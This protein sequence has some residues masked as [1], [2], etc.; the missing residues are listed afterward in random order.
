MQV[1]PCAD[2]GGTLA[3]NAANSTSDECCS[4]SYVTQGESFVAMPSTAAEVSYSYQQHAA[5]VLLLITCSYV[6]LK[7]VWKA[8]SAAEVL[9]LTMVRCQQAFRCAFLAVALLIL[10]FGY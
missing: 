1:E 6:Y 3:A 8:C 7:L 10:F 4:V 5:G 9:L 2:A